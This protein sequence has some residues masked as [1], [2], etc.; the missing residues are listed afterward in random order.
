MN[1][2]T[3]EQLW[4][5]PRKRWGATILATL[6][7]SLLSGCAG[8]SAKS[9]SEP[10]GDGISAEVMCEEFVKRKLAIKDLEFN[11]QEHKARKKQWI[12]SGGV[13]TPDG[14]YA[15]YRCNLRL[16]DEKKDLWR[17]DKVVLRRP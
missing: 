9:A 13:T 2:E 10:A 7:L 16:V 12:V 15:N 4:S 17:A 8:E 14:S 1:M 5:Q 11:G 3:R 6:A